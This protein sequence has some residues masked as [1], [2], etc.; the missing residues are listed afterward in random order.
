MMNILME[1]DGKLPEDK[2]RMLAIIDSFVALPE[3]EKLNF[4]VGRRL[5]WYGTLDDLQVAPRR[6]KV[7]QALHHFKSQGCEDF[8]S[9]K[10]SLKSRLI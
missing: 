3:A 10:A 2:D 6:D 9:I 4:M 5:G 7:D 8:E 1:V